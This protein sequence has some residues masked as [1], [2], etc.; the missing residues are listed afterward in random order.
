MTVNFR[1]SHLTLPSPS[2][3]TASPVDSFRFL[4]SRIPPELKWT[5]HMDLETSPAEAAPPEVE[6]TTA[7]AA[8]IIHLLT[9]S[10]CSAP[11]LLHQAGRNQTAQ[12][13]IWRPRTC[14]GPGS[15]TGWAAFLWPPHQGHL[16]FTSP[17]WRVI[18]PPDEQ[19][20]VPEKQEG[21]KSKKS[22]S[23]SCTL[24]TLLPKH[25][26]VQILDFS[27]IISVCY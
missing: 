25:A 4:A 16:C 1:R 17:L 6:P 3:T 20:T 24:R 13:I 11:Q 12:R 5:S 7:A 2:P 19:Q 27:C 21:K 22:N 14:T 26:H 15:G 23:T 10:T 8:H 18:L 9:S